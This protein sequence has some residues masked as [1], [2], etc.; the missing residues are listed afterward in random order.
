MAMRPRTLPAGVTPVVLGSVLAWREGLFTWPATALCL[1]FAVL[2]QIGTNFANDYFDYVKGADTPN[3]VGPTRAVAAGLIQPA[4]MLRATVGV[5]AAAVG[6]GCGLIP[7]G[8][9]GLIGIG[10]VSV[11]CAVG[12]T[13]G[14]YPLAYL[15]LGDIFVFIFFGPVAVGF[16][17]FVHTSYFSIEALG[18]GLGVGALAMNILV[19]NN[20]R[21]RETDRSC[22]KRT[23]AVRF[24][25]RCA[26]VQYQVGLSVAI[27]AYLF[28]WAPSPYSIGIRDTVLIVSGLILL[29]E[30]WRLSRRLV[31][32]VEGPPIGHTFNAILSGTARFLALYGL[33]VSMGLLW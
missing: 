9:W 8:G 31:K 30:H 23:L 2:V 21:D 5:L 13:G 28:L 15:G 4:T 29:A 3:R 27:G 12:Y 18:A 17:F 16:T 33:G 20:L 25:R 6:I 7:Y 14:R 1:G 10:I 11:L 24:G 26:L 32:A 22:G 19:V